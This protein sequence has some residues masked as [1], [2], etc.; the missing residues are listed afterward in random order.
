MCVCQALLKLM[1]PRRAARPDTLEPR[2]E[3][4]C[5]YKQRERET[6]GR[7]EV[8]GKRFWCGGDWMWIWNSSPLSVC[9]C[10]CV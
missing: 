3:Q 4:E 6:D 10:V 2:A 9:V 8:L 5:H 7:G 1:A